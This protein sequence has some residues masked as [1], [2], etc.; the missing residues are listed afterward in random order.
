MSYLECLILAVVG[1][2]LVETGVLLG[3]WLEHRERN[4]KNLE[5]G[6]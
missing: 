6:R 5:N 1:G 4:R 2:I 3:R